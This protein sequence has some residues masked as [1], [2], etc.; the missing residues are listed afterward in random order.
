MR[1]PRGEMPR[2]LIRYRNS[3]KLLSPPA[4]RQEREH[5]L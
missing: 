5:R 2:G 4:R 3:G 1:L